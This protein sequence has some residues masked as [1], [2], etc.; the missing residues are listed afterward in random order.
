MCGWT[1]IAG[2][3]HSTRSVRIRLC[4]LVPAVAAGLLAPGNAL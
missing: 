1:F 2:R 3:R 4:P